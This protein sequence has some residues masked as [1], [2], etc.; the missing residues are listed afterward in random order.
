[1]A[2]GLGVRLDEIRITLERLLLLDALDL[3]RWA[4]DQRPDR[5]PDS[6]ISARACTQSQGGGQ[7][8]TGTG[9]HAAHPE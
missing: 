8:P 6:V 2:V 4:I 7:H 5:L 9:D 3:V 1:M